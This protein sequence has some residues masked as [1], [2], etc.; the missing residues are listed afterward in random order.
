M[1]SDAVALA[2]DRVKFYAR[3]AVLTFTQ[4]CYPN[5]ELLLIDGSAFANRTL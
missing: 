1:N 5:V 4:V 2:L 3:D